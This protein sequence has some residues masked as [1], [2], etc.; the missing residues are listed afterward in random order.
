M[1]GIE[2]TPEMGLQTEME[3]FVMVAVEN[4]RNSNVFIFLDFG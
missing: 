3:S 4:R 2:S 1:F